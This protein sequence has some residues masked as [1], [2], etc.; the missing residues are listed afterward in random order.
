MR[1]CIQAQEAEITCQCG[2]SRL[3]NRRLLDIDTQTSCDD[4]M[5]SSSLTIITDSPGIHHLHILQ[6]ASFIVLCK[7][8]APEIRQGW[9]M[10]NQS[11]RLP[12]NV[13]AYLCAQ[14]RMTTSDVNHCWKAFEGEI[15]GFT[16]LPFWHLTSHLYTPGESI[17]RLRT[18]DLCEPLAERKANI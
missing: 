11:E 16:V 4:P 10:E 15:S 13:M 6:L 8:L 14:L 7:E 5:A 3:R 9:R 18:L 17:P 12:I 1:L 2:R